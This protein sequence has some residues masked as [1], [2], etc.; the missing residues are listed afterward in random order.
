MRHEIDHL[1]E[2]TEREL[3][4]LIAAHLT[5]EDFGSREDDE[6]ERLFIAHRWFIS[7]QDKLRSA[8]CGRTQVTQASANSAEDKRLL[9]ASIID[10]LMHAQ[11]HI[12]IPVTVL[13]VKVAQVGVQK[14]CQ[15][16]TQ[17]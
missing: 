16:Y 7:V 15:G 13:A 11:L 2:L 5:D 3:D 6:E 9:V 14:I 17:E 12:E 10:A 8:I 1:F 4:L